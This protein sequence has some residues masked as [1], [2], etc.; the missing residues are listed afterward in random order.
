MLARLTLYLNQVFNQ[1][2]QL[3]YCLIYFRELDTIVLRKLGKDDYIILKVYCPI[4]LLNTLGKI[5]DV[6]IV[7]R[8]SY[9]VETY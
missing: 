7:K 1:S 3:G 5:I 4:V 2:I 6:I 9:I 8:L